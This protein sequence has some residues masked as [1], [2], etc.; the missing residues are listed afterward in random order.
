VPPVR[1]ILVVDDEAACRLVVQVV[2][3]GAG[4]AVACA[5]NGQ[6]ALDCLRRHDAPCLIL[7]DLH[8]PVVSGWEF[9]L[10]QQ[11]DPTLAAIPVLLVSGEP[12]VAEIAASLGVAGHCPKPLRPEGLLEAVRDILDGRRGDP[13]AS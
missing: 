5:T 3:E 7:L 13:V 4:Y 10:Q 8:M 1:S 9:R 2:L 12:E 6:E 11:A